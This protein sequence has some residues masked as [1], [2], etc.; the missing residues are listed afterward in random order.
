MVSPARAADPG[1]LIQQ[2]SWPGTVDHSANFSLTILKALPVRY[3]AHFS[4]A[5]AE[6]FCR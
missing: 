1:P 2:Q 5:F 3:P 4:N 6:A